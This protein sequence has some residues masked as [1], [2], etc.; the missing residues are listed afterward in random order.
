M[1][2]ST[3]DRRFRPKSQQMQTLEFREASQPLA[4]VTKMEGGDVEFG[5]TMGPLKLFEPSNHT[6]AGRFSRCAASWV[7]ASGKAEIST[8]LVKARLKTELQN[9]EGVPLRLDVR[10]F[11]E[12]GNEV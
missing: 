12:V 8:T 10:M 11:W 2:E 9:L 3:I 6:F 1:Q 5:P 7:A 4:L